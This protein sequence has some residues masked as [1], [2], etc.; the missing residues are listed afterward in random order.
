[1]TYKECPFEAWQLIQ[2]REVIHWLTKEKAMSL[3]KQSFLERI[4]NTLLI[5]LTQNLA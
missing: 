4:E 3:G 5:L 2:A 1:M